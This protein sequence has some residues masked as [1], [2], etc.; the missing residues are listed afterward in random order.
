MKTKIIIFFFF[1]IREKFN[2]IVSKIV[3]QNFMYVVL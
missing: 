2:K 3:I 1:I